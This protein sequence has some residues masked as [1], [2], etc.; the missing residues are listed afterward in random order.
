MGEIEDALVALREFLT[1]RPWG[2]YSED[3]NRRLIEL[4]PA[5][6][7]EG[8]ADETTSKRSEEP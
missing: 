7:Q 3:G 4:S 5:K 8:E 1:E 6:E 2:K